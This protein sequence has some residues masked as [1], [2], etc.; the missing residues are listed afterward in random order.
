MLLG[1]CIILCQAYAG[2]A[3][4]CSCAA[5]LFVAKDRTPLLLLTYCFAGML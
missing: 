5:F 3:Y 4:D 1:K 2:M